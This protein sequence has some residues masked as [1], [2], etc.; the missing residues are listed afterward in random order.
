MEKEN[1]GKLIS[2]FVAMDIN[3]NSDLDKQ[4]PPLQGENFMTWVEIVAPNKDK[5]SGAELKFISPIEKDRIKIVRFE[6]SDVAQEIQRWKA[7]IVYVLGTKPPYHV[8]THFIARKWGK[9]GE[10]KMFLWKT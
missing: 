8:M 9:Y 6:E 3:V 5:A 2:H 7:L 4:F 10:I 1:A